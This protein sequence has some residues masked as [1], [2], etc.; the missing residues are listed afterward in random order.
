MAPHGGLE[1]NEKS[2][3]PIGRTNRNS[4]PA[5]LFFSLQQ[6]ID[7]LLDDFGHGFPRLGSFAGTSPSQASDLVPRMDILETDGAIELSA[8][9]P[10]MQEKDVE[11]T[12]SDNVLTI[13][14]EKKNEKDETK[15]D[16]RLIER[17]YGSF[18]RRLELP[19]GIDATKIEARFSNGV[20]TVTV[21]KAAPTIA[22]KIEVKSAV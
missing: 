10:G 1:M 4:S 13:R 19:A 15:K 11:V 9:L 5:N 22:K 3:N 16:Y 6:E 21:P 2:L 17:P 8:E 20:L 7:R 12:L 14:G 18:A